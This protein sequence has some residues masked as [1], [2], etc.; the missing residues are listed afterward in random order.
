MMLGL[1]TEGNVPRPNFSGTWIFNAGRS[2][3]Q[4]PAPDST[5]FV[6]E[7]DEPRLRIRRTHVAGDSRDTFTLD[8]TTDGQEVSLER[9]GMELQA[10]AFWEN[11]T[12]VFD[13][14]VVRDGEEGSN[15]VR[16]TLAPDLNSL[17][18]VERFRS[19]S[20]NYDNTWALDRSPER[21]S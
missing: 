4:T 18:A 19:D 9:D 2:V 16:Y 3:L 6:I 15:L 8:L 11:D 7:H 14:T 21:G 13:T 12:L 17:V 20:L 1:G 10:R 5:L